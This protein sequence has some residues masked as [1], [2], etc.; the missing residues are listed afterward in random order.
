MGKER[1]L[2]IGNGF[3]L[4]HYLPTRYL[5]FMKVVNRLL[6]LEASGKLANCQYLMYIWGPDSPIYKNDDYIRQCYDVHKQKIHSVQFDK[7][8]IKELVDISR[9]NIWINYFQSC[10]G[11]DIG[12]IDFEKEIGNVL[13]AIQKIMQ[14]DDQ[15][16][17]LVEGLTFQELSS[18]ELKYIDILQYM[19]FVIESS[20][21]LHIKKE[22]CKKGRRI[23]DYVSINRDKIIDELEDNLNDL[24]KALSIYLKEF[25]H[26]IAID[27][28]TDNPIFYNIDKVLNFNYTDTYRKLYEPQKAEVVFIH[29]NIDDEKG[30]ILGINNDAKDELEEMDSY[31]IRF[32]KYYQRA[33]KDTF[34]S[35]DDF[36]DDEKTHYEVSIVGHSIDITDKD[37]LVGL[38]EHPRTKITIYYHNDKAHS[39]QLVNL[40]SLVG[41]NN[42]EQLRNQ[43]KV[44]FKRLAEFRVVDGLYDIEDIKDNYNTYKFRHEYRILE[45]KMDYSNIVLVGNEIV[46]L[47]VRDGN[48]GMFEIMLADYVLSRI[49]FY[50]HQERYMGVVKIVSIFH[51]N[52]NACAGL[53]LKYIKAD[54]EMVDES[55]NI[56]NLFN[57]DFEGVVICVT[58]IQIEQDAY[59][60]ARIETK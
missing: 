10:L 47:S 52:R 53:E 51:D 35:I 39:Q 30:I 43:R 8:Q 56:C 38:M 57:V 23:E 54:G 34:Y 49:E 19:P 42:F 21:I 4:H 26:R 55:S 5:D 16:S 14:Y 58:D 22:Y 20:F 15:T 37:I 48:V 1:V 44:V 7:N 28:F 11:K 59:S 18:M 50:N 60:E 9:N 13:N 6:D 2:V 12:W 25:V 24:A 33:I 29:G 40:I 3:D 31:L 27:T 45:D 36:L 32:K 17:F 46:E 41:K